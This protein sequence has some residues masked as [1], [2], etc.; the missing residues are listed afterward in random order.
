MQGRWFHW[1]RQGS[2]SSKRVPT[3]KRCWLW[4]NFLTGCTVC[5]VD[6]KFCPGYCVYFYF[7]LWAHLW[8]G[9]S[10][11]LEPCPFI[12]F[13]RFIESLSRFCISCLL[14]LFRIQLLFVVKCHVALVIY[15]VLLR[16]VPVNY[17]CNQLC[18]VINC[19][20]ITSHN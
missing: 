2:F 15:F 9:S 20:F 18:F 4:G 16:I 11:G 13:V 14:C 10:L 5:L 12:S 7:G 19:I 3:T 8:R 17:F 1:K 6:A